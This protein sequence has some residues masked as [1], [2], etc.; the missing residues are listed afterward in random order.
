MSRLLA[1]LPGAPQVVGIVMIDSVYPN[2]DIASS[3]SILEVPSFVAPTTSPQVRDKVQ[4]CMEQAYAMIKTWKLP[5]WHPPAT[6]PPTILLRAQ[7]SVPIPADIPADTVARI[8]VLR[9]DPQLG[10]GTYGNNF[11]K[12]VEEIQGHHYNCFD[13]E[14]VSEPDRILL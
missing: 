4:K 11:I 13:G 3:L 6:V 1:A 14:Y 9:N 10:W 5:I 12:S 2:P 8:D 7:Q